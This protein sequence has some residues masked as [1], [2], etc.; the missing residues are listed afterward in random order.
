[1]ADL[2]LGSQSYWMDFG[3]T[4][5]AP[6]LQE[7]GGVVDPYNTLRWM[8]PEN[9]T[10]RIYSPASDVWSYGVVIWE[11]FNPTCLPYQECEDDEVCAGR[12]MKGFLLE[13]PGECPERVGK[14]L[15]ACWYMNPSSRPSF[16]YM[17]SL[18]NRIIIEYP[19]GQ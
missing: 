1:M 9:L 12:I 13:I 14:I 4:T 16:L 11:M 5:T 18:L 8:A 15:K 2:D 17:S 10:N 6:T 3:T 7:E 19:Y